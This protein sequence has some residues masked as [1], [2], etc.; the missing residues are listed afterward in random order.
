M[1]SSDAQPR[2]TIREMNQLPQF[3]VKR[4]LVGGLLAYVGLLV[5]YSLYLALTRALQVDECQ[6]TY[7]AKVLATGQSQEFF[8]NASLFL[9]G[10]LAWI[11]RNLHNSIQIFEAGRLLFLA[12]FWLNISLM[13]ASVGGRLFS[14]RR[15]IALAVAGSLAPL[16]D[17]GF[18]IRHDNLILTGLLLIWWAVR[19]KKWG[20]PAYALAGAI[21]VSLLFIAVKAVVYVIPLSGALLLFPTGNPRKPRLQLI[22]AWIGGAILAG[23]AIRICYGSSGAWDT[24]LAVFRGVSKYSAASNSGEVSSRFWPWIALDRLPGQTPLLLAMTLAACF[25]VAAGLVRNFKT[26]FSWDSN[27]PE[28]LLSIG[29]LGCLF[30]NPSPYP[31]NLVLIVPF[32]FMLSFRYCSD[33]WLKIHDVSVLRPVIVAIVIFSNFWPFI[34]ATMRHIDRPIARQEMLMNLSE[35]LT[36]PVKD[37][38]YDGIG[39]VPTRSSVHHQWYI[40]SLNLD[41]LRTPGLQIH[42]MLTARPAAVVILSYRTD[43]LPKEDRDFIRKRY[44]PLADD[45]RVLG[46]SL[47]VG[48]GSFE[49]FHPGRYCIVPTAAIAPKNTSANSAAELPTNSIT[50]L[51]DGKPLSNLPIEM[52]VGTHQIETSTNSEVSIVWVGPN[53]N[54]VPQL[55]QYDHRYLFMNWY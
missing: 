11:T 7:M 21:T 3:K 31:Y 52:T 36:D 1:V 47:P 46:T 18:E 48:G 22:A 9:L 12:V 10:P 39:M 30:L 44:V 55:A 34:T 16:W 28:A 20:L 42:E 23:V 49:I 14:V 15:L 38:V 6:N 26:F 25:S 8:T 50:G 29:A 4:L 33:I 27:L 54:G 37:P 19:A 45:I 43:W 35:V 40:H 51:L 2:A 17:Y 24:Y 5:A 32:A 53:L 41:L 13:A